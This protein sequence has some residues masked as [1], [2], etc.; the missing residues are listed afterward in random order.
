MV[1]IFET[2][3]DACR[4][5]QLEGDRGRVGRGY[6]N[7]KHQEE[8]CVHPKLAPYTPVNFHSDEGCEFPLGWALAPVRRGYY[9]RL[10]HNS[11]KHVE[12]E[13]VKKAV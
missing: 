8:W 5:Y 12:D 13:A 6:P 9:S 10:L 2:R 11:V 3:G 4:R 7:E 1:F